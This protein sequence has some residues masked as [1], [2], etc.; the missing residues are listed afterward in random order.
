MI[1][2]LFTIEIKA[3]SLNDEEA[4]QRYAGKAKEILPRLPS[5]EVTNIILCSFAQFKVTK[6]LIDYYLC[7]LF[8][9]SAEHH[10][11]RTVL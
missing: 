6:I 2:I 11:S 9:V 5:K 8:S 10:S 1:I 7:P 3:F 4:P